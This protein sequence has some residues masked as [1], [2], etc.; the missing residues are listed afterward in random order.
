MKQNI[1]TV[2]YI[3]L[4]EALSQITALLRLKTSVSQPDEGEY[5]SDATNCYNVTNFFQEPNF[6]DNNS[7]SSVASEPHQNI[8]SFVEEEISSPNP[9][10]NKVNSSELDTSNTGHIRDENGESP[11]TENSPK[12]GGGSDFFIGQLYKDVDNCPNFMKHHQIKT[13][14]FDPEE[15]DWV[16]NSSPFAVQQRPPQEAENLNLAENEPET[17]FRKRTE[18][19]DGVTPETTPLPDIIVKNEFLTSARAE[20]P[21]P[22]LFNNPSEFLFSQ[23][24]TRITGNKSTNFVNNSNKRKRTISKSSPKRLPGSSNLLI[25]SIISKKV[26][27]NTSHKQNNKAVKKQ[28]TYTCK[29]CNSHFTTLYGLRRHSNLHAV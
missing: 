25:K 19:S 17:T 12:E 13:E 4:V 26:A 21:P 14:S 27:R 10:F 28:K 16:R 2:S 15:E 11:T 1:E 24:S 5:V 9:D 29:V 20:S 8:N 22:T 23:Q 7:S 3:S 18:L 6:S